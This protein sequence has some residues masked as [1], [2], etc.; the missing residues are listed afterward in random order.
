MNAIVSISYHP[1]ERGFDLRDE[2]P[3]HRLHLTALVCH[4]PKISL[5]HERR[6]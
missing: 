5:W 2:R 6:R 4:S 1:A 3:N